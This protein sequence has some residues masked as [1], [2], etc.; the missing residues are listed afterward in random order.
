M[1]VSP[2]GGKDDVKI[3]QENALGNMTSGIASNLLLGG[4]KM[5][6]ELLKDN[7]KIMYPVIDNTV[8]PYLEYLIKENLAPKYDYN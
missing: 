7:L 5:P 2:N 1:G 6:F 8:F 4:A 3:A